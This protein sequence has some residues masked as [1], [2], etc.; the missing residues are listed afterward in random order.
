MFAVI[1][2]LEKVGDRP[3]MIEVS[4]KMVE[5][6]RPCAARPCRG[7]RGWESRLYLLVLLAE[8]GTEIGDAKASRT[9][10]EAR[11]L[12]ERLETAFDDPLGDNNEESLD[13]GT[14]DKCAKAWELISKDSPAGPPEAA[15]RAVGLRLRASKMESEDG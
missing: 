5:L 12:A 8:E 1:P 3:R 9:L 6:L 14:L 4:R 7:A 11:E 13:Q 10:E 15:A 2:A